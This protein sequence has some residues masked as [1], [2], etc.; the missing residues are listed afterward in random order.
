MN[1]FKK[2]KVPSLHKKLTIKERV[3]EFWLTNKGLIGIIIIL[4][5]IG[6]LIAMLGFVISNGTYLTGSEANRYEHL[7]QII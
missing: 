3:Y 2:N 4:I 6:L 7:N 1:I 5:C